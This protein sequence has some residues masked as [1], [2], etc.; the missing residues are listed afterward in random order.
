MIS[1]AYL[2][3]YEE[4]RKSPSLRK[5]LRRLRNSSIHFTID[6][7]LKTTIFIKGSLS[8]NKD[9]IPTLRKNLK[10]T[11]VEMN[12][13]TYD[14]ALQKDKRTFF[15]YYFSLV[16]RK[17]YITYTFFNLRDYN[18]KSI[19]IYLLFIYFYI[20]LLINT[21][22]FDESLIHQIYI[23]HGKIFFKQN[24]TRIFCSIL[25][26]KIIIFFVK[27]LSLT[28]MDIIRLKKIEKKEKISLYYSQLIRRLFKRY[29]YFSFVNICSLILSWWYISCFCSLY[30]NT[31][32]YLLINTFI[33]F[34]IALLYPFAFCFIP[35]IMRYYSLKDLSMNSGTIYK[36]SRIIQIL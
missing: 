27:Y 12:W 17:N 19:K 23:N 15:Q 3:D 9:K 32:I 11:D 4:T 26:S 16:Y 21:L 36:I 30:M 34:A 28:E 10:I 31:Q 24:N 25:I 5:S 18:S 1:K 14:F 2:I 35:T 7:M 33:S 8:V 29:I 13:N 22:F 20:F 6:P